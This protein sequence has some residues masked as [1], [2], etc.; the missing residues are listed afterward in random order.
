MTTVVPLAFLLAVLLVRHSVT[1]QTATD[2]KPMGKTI[3][4]IFSQNAYAMS[5]SDE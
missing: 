1:S 5:D 4:E 3:I 2:L